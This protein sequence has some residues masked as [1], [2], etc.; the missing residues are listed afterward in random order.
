MPHRNQSLKK[1]YF[2]GFA[3]SKGHLAIIDLFKGILSGH[4]KLGCKGPAIFL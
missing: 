4:S 2:A 3:I 1:G